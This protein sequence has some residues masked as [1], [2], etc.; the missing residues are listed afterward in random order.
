MLD[1]KKVLAKIL[2]ELKALQVTYTTDYGSTASLTSGQAKNLMSK[3][4]SKGIYLVIGTGTFAAN[5]TGY[6]GLYISTVSG[7]TAGDGR[8]LQHTVANAGSSN[9]VQMQIVGLL[10]LTETKTVYLNARQ[11]S[12]STLNVTYPGLQ[13]IKLGGVV[14][15]LLKALQSL[16]FKGVVVC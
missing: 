15:N 11:N 7:S 5:G 6:R 2:T 9:T 8:F 12:G 16:T 13:V 1:V 4:I 14:H 10:N 3:S